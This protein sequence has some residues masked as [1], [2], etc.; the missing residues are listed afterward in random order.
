VTGG[1]VF[2]DQLDI[3][4]KLEPPT[5]SRAKSRAPDYTQD[6]FGPMAKANGP[7]A[8]LEHAYN[9]GEDS[10]S[11][12]RS[13]PLQVT[14]I[15]ADHT[16]SDFDREH[17]CHCNQMSPRLPVLLSRVCTL[18]D[19]VAIIKIGNFSEVEVAVWDL[20]EFRTPAAQQDVTHLCLFLFRPI[21]AH[22]VKYASQAKRNALTMARSMP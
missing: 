15:I 14:S 10:I 16:T 1:T 21:Y 9:N 5:R 11:R 3:N 18:V 8:K 13:D 22:A 2:T 6:P 12:I 4:L 19:G 17:P 7:V 20:C